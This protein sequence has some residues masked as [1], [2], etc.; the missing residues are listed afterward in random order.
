M[1]G[2][3]IAGDCPPFLL[4]TEETEGNVSF[5]AFLVSLILQFVTWDEGEVVSTG[6]GSYT[7]AIVSE[8]ET[9]FLLT[10]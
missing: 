4:E 2:E 3:T 8:H 5:F 10:E 7:E 6:I 9:K 1:R